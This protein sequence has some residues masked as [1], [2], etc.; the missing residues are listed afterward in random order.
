LKQRKENSA[1]NLFGNQLFINFGVECDC[2]YLSVG[3]N[4]I[5]IFI[6]KTKIL[7]MEKFINTR[8]A[9]SEIEDLIK[10]AMRPF[11]PFLISLLTIF[12]FTSCERGHTDSPPIFSLDRK[13]VQVSSAGGQDSI[14]LN[15]S[16]AWTV[17]NLPT[18]IQINI[19]SGNPG[20]SKLIFSVD[21]NK[22]TQTRTAEITFKGTSV[23]P[24]AVKIIQEGSAPFITVDKTSLQVD[25]GG[26]KDSIVITSN[27]KWNLSTS[28]NSSWIQIDKSSGDSGTTKVLLNFSANTTSNV[29]TEEI[30]IS[31]VLQ[32]A[33][34][35]K[36]GVSQSNL[37]LSNFSPQK[38]PFTTS[39]TLT[40][41]F[42]ANPTVMLNNVAC[43]IISN[44][45]NEI[46]FT[47]PNDATSG[48][49]TLSFSNATLTATS[50][51]I[52]TNTWVKVSDSGLK[53]RLQ[54]GVSFV[55]NDKI[56]FGLG[57]FYDEQQSNK[58]FWI[59]DPS[60]NQWSKGPSL[61]T[62]MYG[63]QS[64]AC[65]F[66]NGI[67]Y[68]GFGSW[69]GV[70]SDVW[71]FNP[72]TNAWKALPYPFGTG[73]ILPIFLAV[74]NSLLV[75]QPA[76]DKGILKKYEPQYN[77][78]NG[79]WT[80]ITTNFPEV[81]AASCFTIGNYAYITGGFASGSSASF[82][83]TTYR[84]DPATNMITT[85]SDNP[86]YFGIASAPCTVL[87]GKAYVLFH[88]YFYKY[89]PTIDKWQ[90]VASA[91]V[92]DTNKIGAYQMAILNGEIYTWYED[93]TMYK[94]IPL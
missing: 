61:P 70:F 28:F 72:A 47:I 4:P 76:Y 19:N 26:P 13:N 3:C 69:G 46:I 42:G 79:S 88:Q 84:F 37:F 85:L 17:E 90:D 83:K 41:S 7:T 34:S 18:W 73:S 66:L 8:K 24:V 67:A 11:F 63:R 44:N 60:T 12:T 23:Q 15:S 55:W 59:F 92:P 74:N 86:S 75:G 71:S 35:V 22:G 25:P 80:T 20:D 82:L 45:T 5:K 31:S 93:G 6:I 50:D 1:M 39:V 33:Q 81:Q 43:P 54:D 62:S 38:G 32:T 52:V 91:L 64:G 2:V 9:V 14:I 65:V 77:S 21:E 68:M 49:I 58:D 53:G 56:Y 30:V 40:G 57:L 48:K 51:F 94:Y 89:D 27:T 16:V 10:N 29:R 78:G 36:V 87:N